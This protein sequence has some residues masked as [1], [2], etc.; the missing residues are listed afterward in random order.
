M[1]IN[2]IN[3]GGLDDI[4]RRKKDKYMYYL[5]HIYIPNHLKI[6]ITQISCVDMGYYQSYLGILK[7]AKNLY[8]FHFLVNKMIY[9]INPGI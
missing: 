8:Y 3:R 5:I 6:D 1:V 9:P 2:R 7:Y 4:N